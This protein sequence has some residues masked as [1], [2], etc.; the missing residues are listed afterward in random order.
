LGITDRSA[1]LNPTAPQPESAPRRPT[2]HPERMNTPTAFL[3]LLA[4][5]AAAPIA[6]GQAPINEILKF[7]AAD[8]Q[9][10]DELGFSVAVSATTAVL[11]APRVDDN[12]LNAGAVYLFDLATGQQRHKLVPTDT[13]GLENTGYSV[14]VSG[15]TA[16][17]GARFADAAYLFDTETGL[18]LHKLT[19]P[20]PDQADDLGHSVDIDGPLAI[21]GAPE[22][23]S[24]DPDAGS[25]LV[26]DT[27][28]GA[29]IA[30]LTP[31][32]GA[33]FDRFGSSVAISGDLAVVG[34]VSDVPGEDTGAAYVFD[35]RTGEQLFKL[36]ANDA[37]AGDHFGAAVDIDGTTIVVGAPSDR[38][39]NSGSAERTGSAYVFDA[40]TGT[41]IAK[42]TPDEPMQAEDRV[43]T[44]VSV[45]GTT[46]VVGN[47]GDRVGVHKSGSAYIFDARTGQQRAKLAASDAEWEDELGVAV[48][49]LGQTVIAGS[50]RNDTVTWTTG[51][52]YLFRLDDGI[53][54][55]N[56]A[57]LAFPLGVLDLTDIVTFVTAF[58]AADTGADLNADG[59]Y[60]LA[61]VNIFVLVFI[62][63][64]P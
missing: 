31:D 20:E 39:E 36:T 22:I 59:V 48:A 55:C 2:G 52:A 35:A 21:A 5:M 6:R 53:G 9:R 11:G 45:S 38:D 16:I 54:G 23:F 14:G 17:A 4:G 18:Q 3:S 1:T 62:A 8:A 28:S 13:F 37:D 63:G 12:G 51:A 50:A 27:A 33:P 44:S 25:A 42:L 60:D 58:N 61:D 46:A 64:C 43:G 41:Q 26:F 56:P 49:V 10:D 34:A 15:T 47:P 29:R 7:T 24:S 32:D 40:T 19:A 30:T 57:D